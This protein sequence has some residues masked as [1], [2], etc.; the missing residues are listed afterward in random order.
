MFRRLVNATAFHWFNVL[1]LKCIIFYEMAELIE[2]IFCCFFIC[3]SWKEFIFRRRFFFCL[4]FF[5]SEGVSKDILL[6]FWSLESVLIT[7]NEWEILN[8]NSAYVILVSSFFL[9]ACKKDLDVAQVPAVR[10]FVFYL[11]NCIRTCIVFACCY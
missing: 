1:F 11:K 4:P 8:E 2:Y 9:L 10:N 7:R 3:L 6:Q 5:K